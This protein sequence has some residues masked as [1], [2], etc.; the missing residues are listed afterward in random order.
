MVAMCVAAIKR[1]G[2]KNKDG[3]EFTGPP[4]NLLRFK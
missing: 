2:R 1:D 4:E 3:P